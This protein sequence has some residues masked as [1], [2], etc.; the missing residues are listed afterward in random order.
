MTTITAARTAP[1]QVGRGGFLS[2][3]GFITGRW[4]RAQYRSPALIV[5]TLVQPAIWL[6][7][8][9]QLFKGVVALPG[10][11]DSSY[12][13]FL[14]PG[15]VMMTALMTS[16]WNGT[17]FI[18]DME[19]GVMDR[20]L[21]SPVRRGA[22]MAGQLISNGTTTILQTILVFAIGFAAGA[23]YD[24]GVVG[25]LVTIV[26]SMLVGTAFGSLSNAVA[27]LTR[28]QEA[29]IGI[30]QFIS[31]PLTFLSSIMLDPKLAPHWVGVAAR[32]N[33]VDWAAIAARQALSANPDWSSAGRHSAYLLAF[34]LIVAYLSTRA[35][36]TYQRSV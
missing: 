27:L 6:L 7:L 20:M 11:S 12:I 34:T 25:Y 31:L 32:F 5:F 36:R 15:I 14:T 8:F 29:L 21:A 2:H 24:G 28:Q 35:F 23:R 3:T 33:P 9:G 30:S 4:L 16:G 19:R 26:V 10:F 13:A 1:A 18:A 22:L 17:T